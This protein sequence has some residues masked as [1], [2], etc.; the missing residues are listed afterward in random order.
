MGEVLIATSGYSYDDWKGVFYPEGLPR[1]EYLRYYAL[2][3][4]FVE[5][6]FSYYAMPTPRGLASM[7]NRTP[8]HFG[9]SIKA[10]R[11]LTHEPG[12]HWRDDAATFARAA[13]VLAD[14]GKLLAVLVQLP[15]RFHHTPENRTFL[16]S[17]LDALAPLPRVVEFRNDEWNG[18]RVLSEL[19]RRGVG[20]AMVDRPDLPGLPPLTD[21]VTGGLGY[22]RF[23]G[24]N[25]DAWWT[26]D[27]AG[28]YD[29]LYSRAE[30]ESAA[31]RLRRMAQ[32]G[33]VL[34]AFNNHPSGYAVRNANE[35]K[36]IFSP[37]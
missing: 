20:L 34:V 35:L 32:Q 17:L 9:F 8:S 3:F 16:A 1:S 14:A 15:F 18:E 11:S 23:H 13:W 21:T 12:T 4:P 27:A 7:V 2:F 36:D 25:A 24:R 33:R 5:L 30:L 22:L 26:G 37:S 28:R 31:P 19:D 29:Y 10:H 6:N